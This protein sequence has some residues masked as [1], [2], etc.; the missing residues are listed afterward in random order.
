[1]TPN[2]YSFLPWLRAGIATRIG[3]DPAAT[4]TSDR[5]SIPVRLLVTG[6]PRVAGQQLAT[7]VDR[8]VEIYGPG[9]VVGL[10]RRAI[11]RVEPQPAVTNAEPNYLAH[12]EFYDENLP[13]RYS[14]AAPDGVTRRLAPWLAL[15]VL[16]GP[17][18]GEDAEFA[19]GAGSGPLP[20]VTVAD[21]QGTLPP[22]NQLGAWAHVHVNGELVAA[23][24]SS[25]PAAALAALEHV[26]ATNP[27]AACSRIMCPRRLRPN[28]SYHA[29]LVPAFET[30]RLAGLGVDPATVPGLPDA[31]HPAWGL[32]LY[33]GQPAAGALPYYHRWAFTTGSAGDFEH[34]VRLLVPGT[35]DER[36]GRRDVDVHNSAG[37]GLPGIT[38]PAFLHGVLRLGGALRVPRDPDDPPDP[39]E[40]WDDTD[41][42]PY[43]HP[44]QKA[45]A[46][47]VNLADAYLDHTAKQ[48]N[49][50][51]SDPAA[52]DLR[53][54]VDPI[55]TPPLYGRWHAVTSR[56]LTD[57]HGAP[58]P[59]DRNWVHKLNLDPR[60][61]IP[62]NFGTQVVQQRQEEFM[63]AAWA[64]IGDVRKANDTMRTA[65][66]A[67]EVGYA[68]HLKH[69]EPP[70]TTQTLAGDP[71]ALVSGRA[72][73][74]TAPAS[75]RVVAELTGNP[76][77]LSA[78]AEPV[79]VGFH[80][81]RSRVGSAPLSPVMRRITRPGSRL[82]RTLPFG[83][84]NPPADTLVDRMDKDID[85]DPDA[86]TA[87]PPKAVPA[88]VVTPEQLHDVLHPPV[89]DP[90]V[91]G[92][93]HPLDELGTSPDFELTMPGDQFIPST[94]QTD[95]PEATR[96][97]K[98]LG[99]LYT[100]RDAAAA[101]GQVTPRDP[102]NVTAATTAMVTG[103]SADETVLANVLGS[104]H[105][106]A[107][108]APVAEKFLEAM[109]YPRID[110]PM[111]KALLDMSTDVFVPNLNLIPPNTIT[112]LE[113]NQ[114]FI[115][116]Y[117]VGLNHEMARELLW[118][119]YPTDQRG[120]PFRQF[121]DPRPALP[122]P[123]ETD[124]E[125]RERLYDI[126]PIHEWPPT[127]TLGQNDKQDAGKTE[128]E[129]VLVIRGE[130]L[131]KYPNA[132]VYAHK[133]RWNPENGPPDP[134]QE[135]DLVDLGDPANPTKDE[136]RLPIYE[137]TVAP[138]VYLL[139]FDLTQ[140]AAEGKKAP[141]DAGWFF[142]IK[143]R[144]GDPRFGLDLDRAEAVEVWNDLSWP[145]VGTEPDGFVTLDDTT[146][147]VE[148]VEKL[149]DP[150]DQEKQDQ[151]DDDRHIPTWHQNLSSADVAYI[152]FQAPVLMAVH[153]Q[154]MLP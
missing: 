85:S 17:Q 68:L 74:L 25:D 26:L 108:L 5:A 114:E 123:N 121:W 71:T 40:T 112:L 80:V 124:D 39:H 110:L 134:T 14:P 29:F 4:T 81:G 46:E 141:G 38:A 133:A 113:T 109:A 101:G 32:D 62:A 35:P 50:K 91:A 2:A 51:L 44:F 122:L 151:H 72:L 47:L 33:D 107:R 18:P 57:E 94:G 144:P 45:L 88:A 78:A 129:L 53:K 118:R 19:E 52:V 89:P 61:R 27:D 142:V 97:K 99:E 7:V 140:E 92:S 103:L 42:L 150:R 9:D 90:A 34:L 83:A 60:F 6:E 146:Q 54:E 82:M 106:P 36:V 66:L 117:L 67:R 37:P 30:G 56:L 22:P 84:N 137:A 3:A 100:G 12:I 143:E 41:E 23:V 75:S 111:Y 55:I 24:E 93:G 1:V 48:A 28:T 86:V 136:I 104:L 127:N 120:S 10:D 73:A 63:A 95:S 138:D 13:W 15:V 132:A 115:E 16:A 139:G 87:A 65:Q 105:L 77:A 49:Q 152:L 126:E 69:V 20:F 98:A 11:S 31:Q 147:S 59:N 130:L 116:A 125:R 96:F 153:A 154:E 76:A 119:E 79:A 8:M 58:L 43:P 64:Q 128:D 21:P 70:A 135:R 148:V 145:D 102:L 131:K 149:T